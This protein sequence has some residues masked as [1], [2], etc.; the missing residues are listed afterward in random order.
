MMETSILGLSLQME[1]ALS[2][3]QMGAGTMEPGSKGK[4]MGTGFSPGES[5]E[6]MK[7]TMDS[8]WMARNKVRE[9]FTLLPAMF[10]KGTGKTAKWMAKEF[11][12]MIKTKY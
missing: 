4:C 1:T 12:T 2:S 8:M 7:S 6:R 11:Y 5:R 10:S 9:F 3:F